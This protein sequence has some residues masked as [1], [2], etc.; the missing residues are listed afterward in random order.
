MY[1]KKMIKCDECGKMTEYSRNRK[2]CPEC[3]KK[4]HLK[5]IND[6][7]KTP[8]GKKSHKN[9]AEKYQ[10][11]PEV[12]REMYQNFKEWI[13]TPKGKKYV[14]RQRK[15]ARERYHKLTIEQKER[16]TKLRKIW[17]KTPNGIAYKKRGSK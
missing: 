3:S 2:F 8:K 10:S 16:K 12:K 17:L 5:Q 15:L 1:G 4:R 9:S 11:R 6:W 7:G 13:K 14:K